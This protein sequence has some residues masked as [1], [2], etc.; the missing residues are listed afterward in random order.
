MAASYQIKLIDRKELASETFGC[1]FEK[2]EGFHFNPGQTLRLTL[3]NLPETDTE[4]NT[5][6]FSIASAPIEKTLLIASRTGKTAFKH[7]LSSLPIGSQVNIRGPFGD[8]L[9]HK[10]TSRPAVFLAG[11]IGI[12]PF[13]SILVQAKEE[14]L[15]HDFFLF[16]FNRK[17]MERNLKSI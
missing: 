16:Y 11:G 5:R 15:T 9:L 12:T 2:P 10:D 14:K 1:Y 7:H 13:R 17:P 3:L 8:F 4:G 6:L